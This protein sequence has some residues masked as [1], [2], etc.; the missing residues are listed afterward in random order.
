[1]FENVTTVHLR[2]SVIIVIKVISLII[3]NNFAKLCTLVL[4]LLLIGI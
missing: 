1:M 4:A 3:V 2:G